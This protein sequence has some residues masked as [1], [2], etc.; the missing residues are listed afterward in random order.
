M[1]RDDDKSLGDQN[2][3]DGGEQSSDRAD[4]SLGDEATFGGNAGYVDDAVDDDMEVIDLAARYTTEG[5]LGKGGMGEVLL[6]TDTRLNRKVAIKRILGSAARSKTAVNRFM[7]EAQS[8]AALNHPNIVQIYDYGRAKDGPF[9]IMEYVEGSSLLDKCREGAIPLE[10]A[11]DV[12]CQLCDGLSKAHAANIVHRDIK[13]ANVLLN[14]YGVPKLTDFGLAKD[15]AVDTGMTMAGAVIGTLDFM[16]P[17]QRKDA[18]LTDARSDL[19]SLAATL[20]QMVTGKSPKI[21]KFNDVPKTLQDVLGKALEDE[22]EDRYQSAIDLRDALKESLQSSGADIS[23]I[24]AGECPQCRT[25]NDSSRKFC[26]SCA[27]SLEAPCLSCS[28]GMPMWENVCGSCGSKQEGLLRERREAMDANKVH[29]EELSTDYQYAAA[30]RIAE[31]LGSETDLRLQHLKSW[32][33]RFI[34]D[35]E[36]ERQRELSRAAELLGESL[37]HEKAH[38]Y[39]SGV[40]ALEQVPE[41]L[42]AEEVHGQSETIAKVL[43]RLRGKQTQCERLSK[44]IRVRVQ[45]RRLN[46][47]LGEVNKLLELMPIRDDLVKLKDQLITRDAKMQKVRDESYQEAQEALSSQ[48]YQQCLAA[49]SRID[50]RLE[51]A[52]LR[53]L[54]SEARRKKQRLTELQDHIRT[55]ISKK[56][57]DGLLADVIA[58][59]SLQQGNSELEKLRDQL[60]T[61]SDKQSEQVEA[62][63]V[64]ANQLR[65]HGKF[66]AAVETLKQIPEFLCNED[67]ESLRSVCVSLESQRNEAIA[68][69]RSALQTESFAKGLSESSTYHSMLNSDDS[70]QDANFMALRQQVESARD[71]Q[72]EEQKATDRR[73]ALLKRIWICV[74]TAVA[75]FC[76]MIAVI[77]Q[78]SVQRANQLAS[79]LEGKRWEEVLLMEPENVMALIGRANQKLVSVNPDL[80]WILSEVEKI[81]S[82]DPAN[83][84]I[85]RINGSV[86]VLK[87]IEASEAGDVDL[88]EMKLREAQRLIFDAANLDRA[89]KALAMAYAKRAESAV[90]SGKLTDA[91]AD[92]SMAKSFDPQVE[93]SKEFA[94]AAAELTASELVREYKQKPT[95]AKLTEVISSLSD[96]EKLDPDSSEL[97]TLRSSLQLMAQ[98]QAESDAEA[99]VAAYEQDATDINLDNAV[100]AVNVAEELALDSSK[101]ILANLRS[102]IGTV[103]MRS[104]QLFET[105][106]S[107]AN[108]QAAIR[109][110]SQMQTMLDDSS[111]VTTAKDR[112][113]NA[114]VT[115]LGEIPLDQAIV[116]I[117]FLQVLK[118][119]QT[120]KKAANRLIGSQLVKRFRD[121]LAKS[122]YESASKDFAAIAK[123][124]AAAANQI[125]SDWLNIPKEDYI[126][127]PPSVLTKLPPSVLSNVLPRGL[128][129]LPDA[130]IV[131]LPP[132]TNTIGMS[133]KWIPSGTFVMGSPR[134][135]V[136]EKPIHQVTLSQPFLLGVH[137]VTQEQYERVMGKNPSR[138]QGPSNPVDSMSWKDAMEFCRKLSELPGERSAGRLYRLPTEA[139]WEYSCRAG[140]TTAYSFGDRKL[141][142]DNYAWYVGN[143]GSK[144]HPVGLKQANSWGLHD[145]YGNVW[146][147][148]SDWYGDYTSGV[149]IDPRGP[150][151]GT[152]RVGRGGTWKGPDDNWRSADRAAG[153]PS[154]RYENYGFR[155]VCVTSGQ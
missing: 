77:W 19:W 125:S 152:R 96:L 69:L 11:I 105:N 74:G 110:L 115:R 149:V 155:V 47:L 100:S 140:T 40:K 23:D 59:L 42:H 73:E 66:E 145:M 62:I 118:A 58:C 56:Q 4:Q 32:S 103:L 6:A 84:E 95:Q 81:K 123:L 55:A 128:S 151:N 17:E 153:D 116:D 35:C 93:L 22:K 65:T 43:S 48:N 108:L 20:Y 87:S 72:E 121:S 82:L 49:L 38:D 150:K 131:D 44:S 37:A 113:I 91:K 99:V 64:K 106:R 7:T 52:E 147:W 94:I 119:N 24:G 148:C 29:A 111:L 122:D 13:P 139:E 68:A 120:A 26:R 142:L 36:K 146:E 2:T 34:A 31:E 45:S 134:G 39:P 1:P 135:N 3:F 63:L 89:K 25:K 92:A 143:S 71:R 83:P 33:E 112:V 137:E 41:A 8:I 138:F 130:V 102:R 136:D 144:T 53:N 15:E 104:I 50:P 78:I 75:G 109:T 132:I 98:S 133:L 18:A 88:G 46:G 12:T 107:D 127:I 129:S 54:R 51:D 57:Y 101:P 14:E 86:C 27:G 9:L 97:A 10:E 76:I 79:A 67:V 114:L 30:T 141:D 124:D 16:P 90:V 70:L 117:D 21:I 60:I 85:N 61:R 5:T 28:V 126:N 80:D 154:M